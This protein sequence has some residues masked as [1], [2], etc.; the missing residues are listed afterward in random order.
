MKTMKFMM[1]LLMGS[2]V[3]ASALAQA[4]DPALRKQMQALY[5][6]YDKMIAKGDV[7][8]LIA[9]LDPSF[10]AVDTEGKRT[11]YAEVKAQYQ[12]IFDTYRD[13]KSVTSVKHVQSQGGEVTV[14]AE[15]VINFKA[16]QGNRWVAQKMT[17]RFAETLRPVNG[18]WKITYSQQLPMNEPWS[19]GGR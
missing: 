1:S 12:S 14:W 11:S 15:V 10:V 17:H 6:S 19:F 18:V 4:E 13:C 8:G 16:K 3:I 9:T 2:V 7:K 5:A